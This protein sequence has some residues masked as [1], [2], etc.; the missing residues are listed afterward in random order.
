[1]GRRAGYSSYGD[2]EGEPRE[3]EPEQRSSTRASYSTACLRQLPDVEGEPEPAVTPFTPPR[4]PASRG[5]TLPAART[6]QGRRC[7]S[8]DAT[9]LAGARARV[10]DPAPRAA[11]GPLD[12]AKGVYT[13][14][15]SLNPST[16]RAALLE[17]RARLM[18]HHPTPS[19]RVLWQALR[20]QRLG[21][22]FRRQVPLGP[23]IV[24]LLAP[25]VRLV[26][27]VDGAYHAARHQ[28]DAR[29]ERWLRRNGYR[30]VRV[31]AALVLHD[32]V[33]AL[34]VIK[35]AL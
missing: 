19:E 26:V 21:V 27:E 34:M 23:Y 6:G 35:A 7:C 11:P 15:S 9:E 8:V 4:G 29:R 3:Q 33:G 2:H 13:L 5:R 16:A 10:M 30:V 12:G 28:A 1:V 24:D 14:S 17:S 18:R 20:G 32:L 22:A 25:A 31:P